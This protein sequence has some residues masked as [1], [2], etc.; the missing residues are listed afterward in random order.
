MAGKAKAPVLRL[1]LMVAAGWVVAFW[2]ARLARGEDGVLWMSVAAL[3]CLVPGWVVVLL[4]KLTIFRGDLA[5]ILGQM[6]VR[7]LAI[8][9]TCGLVRWQQPQF[10]FFDFYGWVIWFYLLAMIVEVV[11]LREKFDALPVERDANDRLPAG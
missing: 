4:E 3:S 2:P 7:F 6:G 9:V 11:L 8:V 5:L 10:G 1:T